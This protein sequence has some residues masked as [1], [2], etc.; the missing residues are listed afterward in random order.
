MAKRV[1]IAGG[2][3]AGLTCA[4]ALVDQ[5]F[6]VT[7]IEGLPYL[8]GRASTF[9]DK[10][11]DW[12]EQGLHLFLGV[13]SELKALLR[14]VGSEP[15]A[16]L[17]WMQEVRLQDPEGAQATFFINPLR[18]PVKTVVSIAGQN[19]YL[20]PLDK[21]S[22]VPIA[23]PGV[24]SMEHLRAQHDGETIVDWWERVSGD[25]TVLERFIR[26]FCRGIQFSEPEQFSAYNFLGWI[27]HIAYDLPHA[28][29][30]GYRGAREEVFFQPLARYL[31]ER[32][33]TIHTG[34]KLREILY[35]S[36]KEGGA[37]DGFVL[38][39]GER[40]QADV[41][42]A[43]IP[44]WALVPL[45][46]APLRREPFFERLAALPV[47][48]AISVQLWFDRDVVGGTEAFTLVA[49]SHACVYQDQSRNAYPYGE[50]SRLS[51][52]VSPAD[53]LLEDPDEALVRR[54]CESLGKVQPAIREAKVLKSVVLKHRKHLVRPLPGAMSQRPAQATPVPNLFLAGDW[55]QQPFFGSQEGAVRGGNA[56]AREILRSL[57]ERKG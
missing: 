48:P 1:V 18:S 25:V 45:V 23:A 6:T 3:L 49:H 53:D 29:L 41:Y 39:N 38:E 22:L 17:F 10:D 5:G 33:A 19:D 21:L 37:V 7:V 57:S 54:V 14:D 40:L 2:G 31:K 9:R 8:G 20:G 34:V 15:D 56:C 36:G 46:P 47:A 52:I 13:Y 26:P 27:H 30:G 28:L 51:V 50:G 16:A 32:G 44:V 24:L 43:A 35:T 55:T 4:K 11:G 12:V 42:V